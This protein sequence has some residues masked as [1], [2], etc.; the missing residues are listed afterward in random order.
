MLHTNVARAQRDGPLVSGGATRYPRY[1][2]ATKLLETR[3]G[4]LVCEARG[5]AGAQLALST[6][7]QLMPNRRATDAQLT[8]NCR[9]TDAKLTPN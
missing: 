1:N 3:S 2:L 8:P 7:S 6:G 4:R 5:A 9:S